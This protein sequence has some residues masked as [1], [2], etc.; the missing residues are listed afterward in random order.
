MVISYQMDANFKTAKLNNV[1]S[2]F[3]KIWY[4]KEGLILVLDPLPHFSFLFLFPSRNMR[5]FSRNW[6]EDAQKLQTGPNYG[7]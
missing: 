2:T 7:Q 4:A 1:V 5:N 6:E 3:A